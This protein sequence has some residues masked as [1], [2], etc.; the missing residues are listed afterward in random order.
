MRFPM[1]LN[2]K[3]S[4]GIYKQRL[5]VAG[6]LIALGIF[7]LLYG[8]ITRNWFALPGIGYLIAGVMLLQ[9]ARRSRWLDGDER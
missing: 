4:R 1:F 8:V 2:P 7:A 5:I 6:L 3:T 9:V